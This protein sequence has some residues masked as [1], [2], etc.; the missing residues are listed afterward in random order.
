MLQELRGLFRSGSCLDTTRDSFA[1]MLALTYQMTLSAGEMYFGKHVTPEART[2]LY[3]RDI[4]VNM[5]ERSIRK[6]VV[7]HLTV[8]ETRCDVSSALRLIMLVKDLE[9]IGDYC[10]NLSEVVD[11]QPEPLPDVEIVRELGEIR[12]GVE[13]AFHTLSR[14]FSASDRDQALDFI[15]RGRA[16]AHRCDALITKISHSGYDA[17]TTTALVL[18]TRY[19]KR[20]GGHV[21]NLLTSIVMPLHKVDYFDE[22]EVREGAPS[23]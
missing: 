7:V 10:K 21:L 16:I 9:R 13:D 11:L 15:R 12:K 20:I 5:L 18:G 22:D 2:S 1:E 17:A 19:Y 6:R 8:H 3:Q 23:S 4:Q 14:I